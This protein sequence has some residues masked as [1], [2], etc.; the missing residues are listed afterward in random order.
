[1]GDK[2]GCH[3]LVEC[4]AVHIDGGPDGQHEAYDAPV[5][6]VVLKE[7]LEGDRQS[8]RATARERE[9]ITDDEPPPGKSCVVNDTKEEGLFCCSVPGSNFLPREGSSFCPMK[10]NE[11]PTVFLD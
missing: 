4:S 3:G 2:D 8:G 9:I 11:T 7:A 6:V 5:N 1:M 10:N